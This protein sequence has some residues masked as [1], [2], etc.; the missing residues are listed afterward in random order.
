MTTA[1]HRIEAGFEKFGHFIFRNRFLTLLVVCVI[2]AGFLSQLPK[3]A[4]DTSNEGFLHEDDPILQQYN[5]FR[6]QFGREEMIILAIKT[7]DIFTFDTLARI[8]DLHDEL[9]DN[10]PYLDDIN[11]LINARNTR[12]EGDRLIV[13]DLLEDWPQTPEQLAEIKQRALASQLYKNFI[14]SEDATLTTIMMQTLAYSPSE[15]AEEDLMA[16]FDDEGFGEEDASTPAESQEEPKFLTDQENSEAVQAMRKIIA[17][18]QADDFQ[19]IPA[20]PPVVV[21]KLK[22]SMQ[23]DMQNF[24]RMALLM[25]I[26]VLF[27]LF[28]RVSGVL[29]PLSV[30]ILTLLSTVGLMAATGTALK[31][32]TQILPSLIL[33]V[34]VAAAVHLLAIFYRDYHENG[35]KENAIAYALGHSGLAIVMTSMTTAAGLMSFAASEVSP[36]AD[37]GR[38]AGAGVMISLIYTLVLVPTLIAIFPIKHKVGKTETANQP[39]IDK[40][41][42]WASHFSVANAKPIAITSGVILVVALISLLNIQFHHDPLKW[43]PKEWEIRKATELIDES[44]KGS[45]T[46]EAVIDTG[47]ENGLYEPAILNRVQQVHDNFEGREFTDD[48]FIGKTVSVADI[49]KESNR[50]LHANKQEFYSIPQNRDLIAQELLLFE[51]SGSDDLEDF[52][53]SQF[54]MAR[55]TFKGPWVDAGTSADVIKQTQT[56]LEQSFG[57]DADIYL[58]GMGSL[59]ART[60]SASIEST[61]QSYLIAAVVIT[62]M[63]ILLLGEV[64]LGLISMIPN[65]LP[66]VI[67]LGVMAAM[68]IPLDMFTMLV[69]SIA[70]GL[71]VDDTIHFMHNFKRYYHNTGDVQESVRRTLMSTG[72]AILVTTIV[73]CLGFFIFMAASMNNVFRFGAL[74]GSTILLALLADLFLAPALMQLLYGKKQPNATVKT[75]EI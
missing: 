64:K 31:L 50:A 74:V 28:R 65:L 73:L 23:H 38:F 29:L 53:D 47:K 26:V 13:E 62:F 46:I 61:R 16:G 5:Q 66:I 40:L 3:I 70:I 54:S 25:I 58:T 12:G 43:M 48:F 56:E 35:N 4:I 67:A 19:I 52:V 37:L 55:I 11:S 15:Q 34:S 9:E 10:V 17:K 39:F 60:M 59:F 71:A 27:I 6:D 45:T 20:G 69:G 8:R 68:K 2:A 7:P 36:I 75:Q 14:L 18:Y 24:T 32:P 49:I 41:L 51:N 44:L 42:T 57:D 21:D 22:A 30:V 63:M 1:R 33:A 72:R